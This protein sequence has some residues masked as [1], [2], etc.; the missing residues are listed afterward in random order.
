MQVLVNFPILLIKYLQIVI[1]ASVK[2]GIH[3]VAG[4]RGHLIRFPAWPIKH[5]IKFKIYILYFT[6]TK[7]PEIISI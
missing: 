7:F 4:S 1:A 3:S 2:T 6:Y 5:G